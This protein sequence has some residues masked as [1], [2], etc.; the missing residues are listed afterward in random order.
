MKINVKVDIDAEKIANK[1]I[2]KDVKL[3][4][5]QTWYRL[6]QEFVPMKNGGLYDDTEVTD[7]YI[8]HKKPYAKRIYNGKDFNFSKDE[9]RFATAEWDKVSFKSQGDKLKKDIENYIKRR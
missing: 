4:A 9:H 7:E 3:F 8:W 6:Y 1:V 5:N 2:N